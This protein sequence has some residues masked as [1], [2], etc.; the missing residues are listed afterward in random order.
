M[1]GDD[2]DRDDVD[3]D[4]CVPEELEFDPRCVGPRDPEELEFDPR[5]VDE[6]AGDQGGLMGLGDSLT[7]ELGRVDR[8]DRRNPTVPEELE[9]DP[10]CVDGEADGRGGWG[11]LALL[12][13]RF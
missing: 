5:C 6:E 9:F 2:V 12:S 1:D 3:R 7:L 10:R 8:D 4:A 11:R 13:A